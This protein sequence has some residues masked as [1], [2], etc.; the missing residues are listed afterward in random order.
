MPV[1]PVSADPRLSRFN[2]LPR[3]LFFDDFDEGVSG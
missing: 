2:P 3:I 1:Q